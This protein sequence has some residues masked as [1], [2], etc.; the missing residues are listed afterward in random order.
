[1]SEPMEILW[2]VQKKISE[3][4]QEIEIIF[5]EMKKHSNIK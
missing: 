3:I 5:M 4:L 1:M 2:M